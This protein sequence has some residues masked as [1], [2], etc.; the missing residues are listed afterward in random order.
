MKFFYHFIYI[1]LILTALGNQNL[2][3][4]SW[5]KVTTIPPP[6]DQGYWLDI[7][8]LNS[9]YG[10]ICGFGGRV[11]RTTDGGQTWSGSFIPFMDQLESIQFT[12][13]N[14]GYASGPQRIF[15]S[16]DGGIT[17]TDITPPTA[18]EIWGLNFYDDN[19]G[20][21]V[22]GG[23]IDNQGLWKTTDG[24]AT[25]TEYID[26]IPNSGLTHVIMY[27]PNGLCYAV[28]SGR[29]WESLDGG[30]TWSVISKS[31]DNLWQ[32][33]ISNIGNSFLV[34][35]AGINC[36]GQ[37]DNGGMHFT[38]D[39]GLTWN[40]YS[41]GVPMFGTYLTGLK[42]GWG[43]GFDM[44]VYY[45]SDAG[46]TWQL[47]NCGIE[48]GKKMDCLWFE[49]PTNGWVVG[50]GVYHL[51][52]DWQNVTKLNISYGD[53]CIPGF[54]LDT[55]WIKNYSFSNA[56][57]VTTN[58][59]GVNFEDFSIVSP[60][61]SFPVSA[62]DSQMIVI[63]FN[64]KTT[65]SKDAKLDVK[66]IG[67]TN[68]FTIDL[69]GNA[70][71]ATTK[72]DNTLLQINPAYCG[73]PAS[74]SIRWTTNSIDNLIT[75]IK[76]D[77]GAV[78]ITSGTLLPLN[79][80]STGVFTNF[81]ASLSDTGWFTTRFRVIIYPC[82]KD[83]LITVEAYGVSPIITADDKLFFNVNCSPDALDT[84][85]VFNTGNFD[86]IISGYDFN[87]ANT[88]FS[89][90]GWTSGRNFPII[91]KP[92]EA[93]SLIIKYAPVL[94][95]SHNAVLSLIN[96]DSTYKRG[97]KNPFYI[98]ISG[99][100]AS[101]NLS[102][103]D[104]L[105]NVGDICLGDSAEIFVP[106]KNT[107][108]STATLQNPAYNAK[109]Y[110]L[111]LIG[112]AFPLQLGLNDSVACR[113]LFK[114][115]T[116]KPYSDTIII[117]STPCN[118]DI[119]III[120]ANCIRS[121][122]T[123]NPNSISDVIQT[124]FP[125]KKSVRI[126][127]GGNVNL[128]VKDIYLKPSRSDWTLNYS[129][130][131]PHNMAPGDSVTFDIELTASKDTTLKGSLCFLTES[132]CPVELCIPLDILSHSIWLTT[133]TDSVAFDYRKCN[134]GLVNDTITV[135][136]EGIMPDTIVQF[137]LNPPG[138]PF[139]I[140]NPP[141]LPH[142]IAEGEKEEYI[143]EFN[144]DSEGVFSTYLLIDSKNLRGLPL[145]LPVSSE[146]HTVVTK[147]D[148]VVYD[149]GNAEP[150][151][152]TLFYNFEFKNIGTLADSLTIQ[153]Q[154]N[155]SG[156]EILP[157]NDFVIPP[158]DSIQIK[159]VLIPALFNSIGKYTEQYLI[160]SNV[161]PFIH[162]VTASVNIVRPRL[163]IEPPQL[164]FGNIW[165]DDSLI[166]Y[167]N[168]TNKSGYRKNITGI[169]IIPVSLQ[170]KFNAA[171][172][173][174][175]PPDTTLK[176]PVIFTAKSEGKESCSIQIIEESSCIDTNYI[177]LTSNVP[178]EVYNT[179]V[180]I[181]NYR[182]VPG[183]TINIALELLTAIP[184][185]KPKGLDFNI[186]FDKYLMYPLN[187]EAKLNNSWQNVQFNDNG[188]SI[189]GSLDSLYAENIFQETGNILYLENIVLK[190]Y[191]DTT[192]LTIADFTPVTSKKV[193]ITRYD[194]LLK[195]DSVCPATGGFHLQ[196][197]PDLKTSLDN[198]VITSDMLVIEAQNPGEQTVSSEIRNIMG[199][200]VLRSSK[201]ISKTNPEINIDIS[202]LPNGLY[203]IAMVSN[204]GLMNRYKFLI[205]R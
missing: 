126:Y 196:L 101:T 41:T 190:S 169:N 157:T 90:E 164:D 76:R 124:G 73:I 178:P 135:T 21:T 62:C 15:K 127:A 182:A 82:L 50:E 55:V 143:I 149:F 58:L 132:G 195:V 99:S 48:N 30:V 200:V 194:G 67:S 53:V 172:P 78:E 42:T 113:I 191:P 203:F 102:P 29:L 37:G 159:L 1:L 205:V 25:W 72:P 131:L 35:Y 204:Y 155:L 129:P 52:P 34:P 183:D 39:A 152:D 27:A 197:V 38:T 188:G 87:L 16:I 18:V 134:P 81:T 32:E 180:K 86:L 176:I 95:G 170:F 59:Y 28:S 14:I 121:E 156:F 107:W 60:T 160:T 91:I 120:K 4:I 57:M 130:A 179:E 46:A 65:G 64:P 192:T 114:P 118:Q 56:V 122:I 150:C 144:A 142:I 31:G 175:V 100:I 74:D 12:S 7:N 24:G 115:D 23:C 8:F 70:K 97:R 104:T 75:D 69:L 148:N 11:I 153:K 198:P 181:G 117:K 47:R 138:P 187:V 136:N 177:N 17:W 40:D 168:I 3:S 51:G 19:N 84:L 193:N 80:Y 112:K 147:P 139:S 128:S 20:L 185:V 110:Q 119:K 10:W 13:P 9:Q 202:S 2:Y 85:P 92:G 154:N 145:K 79:V 61:G 201:L 123:S 96:N 26:T 54:K 173:I 33:Y 105:I 22:G 89:F 66:A 158:G 186:T 103:K 49:T 71:Q 133:S 151:A 36:S 98:A 166:D 141:T 45:T 68:D 199:D 108:D 88:A 106:L 146:F 167:V 111:S 43:C 93:D 44:A 137:E 162:N 165:I 77:S 116:T 109:I 63:E 5:N 83:T 125:L 189:S 94:Y 140:V 6:Y 163:T 161:C 184:R 171:L 174:I